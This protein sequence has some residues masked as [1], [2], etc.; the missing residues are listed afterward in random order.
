MTEVSATLDETPVKV[1]RTL[2]SQ[3]EEIA[4]AHDGKV[5]LHGRLFAQ[6]LHYVFPRDCPFPH[7]SGTA[8]RASP[9]E[10]GEFHASVQEMKS[11]VAGANVS[12]QAAAPK[13]D[14]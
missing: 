1:T 12:E 4:N 2:S 7:K 13:P 3:L 11:H 8:S 10:F 14:E 5:P 6:W 9:Q